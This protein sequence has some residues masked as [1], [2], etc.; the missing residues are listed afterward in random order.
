MNVYAMYIPKSQRGREV[1]RLLELPARVV[2]GRYVANVRD[3]LTPEMAVKIAYILD[4]ERAYAEEADA[5]DQADDLRKDPA[6]WGATPEE[7]EQRAANLESGWWA[8][9]E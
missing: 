7:A 1:A 9:V 6:A 2:C 3:N 8:L 4:P 5:F